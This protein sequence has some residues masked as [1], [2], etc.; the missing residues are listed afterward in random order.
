M[1]KVVKEDSVGPYIR[2]NGAVHRPVPS[3]IRIVGVN[4]L[5]DEPFDQTIKTNGPHV[6]DGCWRYVSG[7]KFKAGDEVNAKNINYTPYS[8]VEGELW[9]THGEYRKGVKTDD[10]FNHGQIYIPE[11]ER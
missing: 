5:T 11:R 1:K 9:T 7:T 10:L 3:I 4:S 8:N 6:I 2:I